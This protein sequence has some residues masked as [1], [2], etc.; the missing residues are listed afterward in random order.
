[1]KKLD[2]LIKYA[3]EFGHDVL[4][5]EYMDDRVSCRVKYFLR[6][7][8]LRH[9]GVRPVEEFCRDYKDYELKLAQWKNAGIFYSPVYDDFDTLIGEEFKRLRNENRI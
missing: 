5:F 3:E 8:A 9:F 4:A 6:S 7:R 2:R 1:M